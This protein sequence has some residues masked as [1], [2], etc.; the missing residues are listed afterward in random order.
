V[1]GDG[2]LIVVVDD[3]AVYGFSRSQ[4][5]PGETTEDTPTVPETTRET[6][7]TSLPVPTSGKVTPRMPTL[8]TPY[9]SAGETPE[10][11]LPPA[12]PLM[13]LGL[14]FLCCAGRK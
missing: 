9:P 7:T 3:F 1:T 10:A 5:A 13:A 14:L 8:P 2:S 11:A 12:V 4:F 6:T